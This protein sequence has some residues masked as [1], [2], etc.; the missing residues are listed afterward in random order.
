MI[1]FTIC[2]YAKNRELYK[3]DARSSIALEPLFNHPPEVNEDEVSG[4]EKLQN[5]SPK[6]DFFLLCFLVEK[7]SHIVAS[8]SNLAVHAFWRKKLFF[9][10]H[11]NKKNRRL[12]WKIFGIDELEA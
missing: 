2:H 3:P 8:G 4:T 11:F 9:T 12:S 5:I 6:Q 10:L 1:E 7:R